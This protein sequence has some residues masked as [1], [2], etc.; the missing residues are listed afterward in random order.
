[1]KVNLDQLPTL[2][3]PG[4]VCAERERL[5]TEFTDALRH[6]VDLQNQQI[7]AV[8]YHDPDFARFDI[9][10]DIAVQRKREAKYALL[11]HLEAH[12]CQKEHGDA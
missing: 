7:H 10:V 1:M 12:G 6:L 11:R 2:R 4:T 8:L 9:L 3:Q 5:T